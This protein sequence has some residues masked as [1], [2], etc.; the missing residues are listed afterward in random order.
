MAAAPTHQQAR[1]IFWEDMKALVPVQFVRAVRESDLTI[2]LVNGSHIRVAGLDKPQRVEGRPQSAD[3]ITGVG[4]G[5]DGSGQRGNAGRRRHAD[6][7]H[8][9]NVGG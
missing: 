2:H 9:W 6:P 1:D 4:V 5:A 3:P 7:R 8:T